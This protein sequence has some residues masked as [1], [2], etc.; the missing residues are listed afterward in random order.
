[1][2]LERFLQ[3]L[4]A[5]QVRLFTEQGQL[6]FQAPKGALTDQDRAQLKAHKEAVM[7]LLTSGNDAAVRAPLTDSQEMIRLVEQRNNGS[8]VYYI[9]MTHELSGTL[10]IPLLQASLQR[11]PERHEALR[12]SVISD[13]AEP[14]QQLADRVEFPVTVHDWT[15]LS[16]T[17]QQEKMAEIRESTRLDLR[18]APL[19]HVHLVKIAPQ[20]FL[21]NCIFHHLVMDGWSVGIFYKEL[22]SIYS[23]GA[24]SRDPLLTPVAM[25]FFA[26][27]QQHSLL[28]PQ[29]LEERFGFWE[30]FLD[31]C[32][33]FTSLPSDFRRPPEQSFA[34]GSVHFRIEKKVLQ[35]IRQTAKI[36]RVTTNTVLMAAYAV[37]LR[38]YTSQRDVVFGVPFSGRTRREIEQACGMFV[39]FLPFRVTMED[40]EPFFSL[41]ER[42]GRI[43]RELQDNANM[44]FSYLLERLQVERRP[45]SSPLFQTIF[46]PL[47]P[48][49]GALD[50]A[51]LKCREMVQHSPIA[52]YETSFYVEEAG[53][54]IAGSIEFAVNLYHDDTVRRWA[55]DYCRLLET[56]T[57]RQD[58]AV[59][60]SCFPA[61][62]GQ[63]GEKR[64][65]VADSTPHTQLL[66]FAEGKPGKN[67]IFLI[68]AVGGGAGIYLDFMQAFGREYPVYGI[69]ARGLLDK[70]EPLLTV[71]AMAAAYCEL[72]RS[73]TKGGPVVLAGCSF[74]GYVA[75]EMALELG[76]QGVTVSATIL[77]DTPSPKYVSDK[78]TD[79]DELYASFLNTETVGQHFEKNL[80]ELKALAPDRKQDYLLK[81]MQQDFPEMKNLQP[82]D[83]QRMLVVLNLNIEAM[84]CYDPRPATTKLVY[85]KAQERD[86]FN[87]DQGQNQWIRLAPAGFECIPVPGNHSSMLS[88]PH[89]RSIAMHMHRILAY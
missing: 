38:Q 45:D 70:D 76:H 44:P 72:V 81:R 85:F 50:F 39:S 84:N 77:L 49:N 21:L 59:G 31:G 11:L 3:Q 73:I 10:D 12:I 1:M 4:A 26:H 7:R 40:E 65:L 57:T 82:D 88:M 75:H 28:S 33:E 52:K 63:R 48:M 51:G 30:Q 87:D 46:D 69:S 37:L 34:G 14:Y 25:G 53:E 13:E 47:P 74:G 62:P 66:R 35:R 18:R 8:Q 43:S 32:P 42:V 6:K 55:A 24:R 17:E 27:A 16:S 61:E 5:K 79:S 19:C 64:F 2:Q 23:A 71:E 58:I 86:M 83:L 15:G 78:I 9:S 60:E 67:P 54:S 20:R 22:A 29:K 56:V 89:V 36:A 41:L 80:A 68:H